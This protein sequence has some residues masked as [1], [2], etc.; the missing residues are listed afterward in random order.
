MN[1][2][3]YEPIKIFYLPRYIG[4]RQSQPNQ[5]DL[6]S[7]VYWNPNVNTDKTGSATLEYFSPDSQGTYRVTVEGFD[8]D[9]N[10]GRAVYRYTVK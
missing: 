10:L 4:P 2:K 9:G 7:T 8:K 6:R 3:G 1:P 5:L